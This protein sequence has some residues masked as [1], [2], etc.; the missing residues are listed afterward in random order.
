MGTIPPVADASHFYDTVAARLLQKMSQCF[1]K[2]SYADHAL[3]VEECQHAIYLAR[4]VLA[5][6]A[7]LEHVD[8][9][10]D[11][12]TAHKRGYFRS[13]TLRGT[14]HRRELQLRLPRKPF[15]D[16]GVAVPESFEEAEH[17]A[18]SILVD[19]RNILQVGL[20]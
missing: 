18:E 4:P 15:D 12:S 9:D 10:G 5:A 16:L 7:T 6:I 1:D 17:L 3:G 13:K 19:Q 8:H 14:E 2:I 20:S 11:G